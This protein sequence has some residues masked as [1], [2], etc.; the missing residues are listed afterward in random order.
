M[1]RTG[2]LN[3]SNRETGVRAD[4]PWTQGRQN[5]QLWTQTDGLMG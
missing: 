2:T 5:R 1:T 4:I 3:T